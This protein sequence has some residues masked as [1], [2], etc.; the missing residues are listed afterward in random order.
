[1]AFGQ[2]EGQRGRGLHVSQI[3]QRAFCV[4]PFIAPT[5]LAVGQRERGR[6]SVQIPLY[7]AE[8]H[9]VTTVVQ[10]F[11]QRLRRGETGVLGDQA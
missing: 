1:M 7:S 2:V 4:A 3:Q 6:K 9:L 8:L 11:V 5:L 10:L